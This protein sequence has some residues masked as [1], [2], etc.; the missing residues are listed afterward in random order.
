[1]VF[2]K[3]HPII[4]VTVVQ[5]LPVNTNSKYSKYR[6]TAPFTLILPVR[7]VNHFFEKNMKIFF[8]LSKKKATSTTVISYYQNA[9]T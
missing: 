4:P 7:R 1:M 8:I 3:K 6:K 5:N 2:W 9:L